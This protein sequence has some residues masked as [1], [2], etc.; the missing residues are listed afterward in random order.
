[1]FAALVPQLTGE[2]LEHAL[3][4]ALDMRGEGAYVR[5]LLTLAP[6]L[7]G[8]Q[9]SQ[10]LTSVLVVALAMMDAQERAHLF[11]QL[12]PHLKGE[13]R[14]QALNHVFETA[15]TETTMAF[16]SQWFRAQ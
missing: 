14:N 15:M 11:T 13:Q 10:T 1:M 3:Q 2:L 7:E 16:P 8:E 12:I 4:A 5:V 6:R 9:R